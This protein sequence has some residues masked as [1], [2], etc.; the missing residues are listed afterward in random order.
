MIRTSGGGNRDLSMMAVPLALF[1]AFALFS[2]GG[3]EQVLRTME[4]TLWVVVDW[5][6]QFIS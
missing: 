2:G 6:G 1:I 3:V 5:V 4:R